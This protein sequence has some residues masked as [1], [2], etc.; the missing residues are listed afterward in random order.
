[1]PL[2]RI[3]RLVGLALLLLPSVGLAEDVCTT[4]ATNPKVEAHFA[5]TQTK[6]LKV[7]GQRVFVSAPSLG[8][9]CYSDSVRFESKTQSPEG[10][11]YECSYNGCGLGT[12]ASVVH[13]KNN[14][15]ILR[16]YHDDPTKFEKLQGWD[17]LSRQEQ[18]KI[19]F[20]NTTSEIYKVVPKTQRAVNLCEKFDSLS[21]RP[22]Q[23]RM[24]DGDRECLSLANNSQ[25]RSI[26]PAILRDDRDE[27]YSKK[28]IRLSEKFSSELSVFL[29][30]GYSIDLNR[31]VS[32]DLN[33]DGK[34]EIVV[35]GEGSSTGGCGCNLKGITLLNEKNEPLPPDDDFSKQLASF[36]QTLGCGDELDIVERNGWYFLE[37]RTR[38]GTRELF[39]FSY[40]S[41]IST[42]PK[43]TYVNVAQL[44]WYPVGEE[45]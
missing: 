6:E 44:P 20:R 22:I 2:E 41:G 40:S 37:K 5:E 43:C 7:D 36:T 29:V 39:S 19:K 27:E 12:A 23:E 31:K 42:V 21:P 10:Y 25:T 15:Y 8:G 35:P 18:A 33:K 1:M 34:K 26:F 24:I 17:K 16:K 32:L 11:S 38:I 13:W 3:N 4:I 30:D 14:L 9:S 28:V 45:K